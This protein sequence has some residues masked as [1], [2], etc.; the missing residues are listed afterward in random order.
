MGLLSCLLTQGRLSTMAS[1]WGELLLLL[2]PLNFSLLENALLLEKFLCNETKF[3][4]GNP[5][6]GDIFGLT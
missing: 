4:V 3:N 5:N 2:L 1:W 6:F